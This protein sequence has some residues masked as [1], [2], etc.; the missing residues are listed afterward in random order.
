MKFDFSSLFSKKASV[1][2][3]AEYESVCLY[4]ESAV[5]KQTEGGEILYC[6]RRRARVKESSHCGDFSYD[7]LKRK[8]RRV[9]NMPK[10]DPDALD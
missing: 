5:K 10:I 4:C 2:P 9:M 3:D 8:P 6:R 1:T 7:L